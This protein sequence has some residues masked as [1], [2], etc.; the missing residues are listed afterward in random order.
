MPRNVSFGDMYVSV[1]P[2]VLLQLIGLT[3]I[4]I[5]PEIAVGLPNYF[6]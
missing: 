5:F 2:F 6:K 4:F 1:G 3:L